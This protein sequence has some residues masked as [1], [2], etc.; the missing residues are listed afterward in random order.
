MNRLIKS[1]IVILMA[2]LSGTVHG[3]ESSEKVNA[4]L[5]LSASIPLNPTKQ[6]VNTGWGVVGGVGYNLSTHHSLIGEFMWNRLS[7]TG[8]ALRPLE[9]VT[10]I[11][12]FEG[13]SN[14]Y[15][16]TGNYRYETG[17]KL[18]GTYFI[19]GGGLYYRT[20]NPS[21]PVTINTIT[22]CTTVWLWWGFSC[23]SGNVTP[24]QSISSRGSSAFG[25]NGGVGLTARVGEAPYRLYLESRYHYAPNKNVNT[26]LV[27]LTFGIRY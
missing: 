3:Q 24:N 19:G 25:V 26:Q 12:R 16:L 13:K 9:T 18:F 20:T 4:N 10:Q 5:G 21:K 2:S 27:V 11:P 6:Y 15:A 17:G 8:F 7:A 22:P 14:L 23:T 1:V